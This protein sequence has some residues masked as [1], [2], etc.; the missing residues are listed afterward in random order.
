MLLDFPYREHWAV[1]GHTVA[2]SVFL[3][4]VFH[5]VA[6]IN[7]PPE[8]VGKPGDLSFVKNITVSPTL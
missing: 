4:V 7:V 1:K 3:V 8:N 5:K 6:E 2:I